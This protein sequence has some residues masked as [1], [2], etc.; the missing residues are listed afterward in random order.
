MEPLAP[1]RPPEK[2]E[3]EKQ[4]GG[5]GVLE[6]TPTQLVRIAAPEPC[7]YPTTMVGIS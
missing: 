7:R 5:D 4:K 2:R 3:K 1:V 6:E